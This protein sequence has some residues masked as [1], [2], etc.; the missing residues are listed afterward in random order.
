MGTRKRNQPRELPM[1]LALIRAKL[2]VGQ[3][4]MASLLQKV[5]PTVQPGM[6]S[7]YERGLLEPSL[8]VLLQY[9]RIGKVTM[10]MLVDDEIK[11]R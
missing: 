5:E 2:E 3:K 4:E 9:A 8:I 6:V 10:E 11:L 1:K 7:R